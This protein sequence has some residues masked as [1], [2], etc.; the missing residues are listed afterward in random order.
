MGKQT[1]G[2]QPK[3]LAMMV[4]TAAQNIDNL[5]SLLPAVKK[6]GAVH[7]AAN[8]KPEHYPIIGENLLGAIKQVLGDGATDEVLKAWEEAF[9]VIAN[10]FIDVEKDIYA[11]NK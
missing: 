6:V 10:I 4:L 9:G 5:E 3:A 7:V 1:S 11:Q 8:V 2:Q